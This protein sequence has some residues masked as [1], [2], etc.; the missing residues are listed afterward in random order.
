MKNRYVKMNKLGFELQENAM[1]H[2]S[3]MMRNIAFL[4]RL[5]RNSIVMLTLIF[6]MLTFSFL[7]WGAVTVNGIKYF[8][9]GKNLQID[10]QYDGR[11]SARPQL[12]LNE[13]NIV[14]NWPAASLV[15][16]ASYPKEMLNP[17]IEADGLNLSFVKLD[18][19]LYHTDKMSW[20][21]QDNT[22]S[23]MIP[24]SEMQS[25]ASSSSNT[26]E[27]S[28]KNFAPKNIAITTSWNSQEIKKTREAKEIPVKPV[29][30]IAVKK[31]DQDYLSYLLSSVDKK[32]EISDQVKVIDKKPEDTQVKKF[33]EPV[34]H[35]VDSNGQKIDQNEKNLHKV[36]GISYTSYLVKMILVLS[37]ILAAIFLLAKLF[38][39]IVVG[40]NK[41][42]FLHNSKVVEVLNTTYL[43]PKKQLL[44]VKVYDQVLL[45]SSSENGVTFLS[46]VKNLSDVLKMGEQEVTGKN[47]D[48]DL[49]LQ[50]NKNNF[51]EDR[52][53]LKDQAKLFE[54]TNVPPEPESKVK[55]AISQKM[56]ALKAWQ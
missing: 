48:T 39:K 15:A 33:A 22:I 32:N 41:L 24:L 42:G 25:F 29:N 18:D 13:K 53:V 26:F 4:K 2:K 50:E 7:S 14:I 56:K 43:S 20:R 37:G 5:G 12:T 23:V 36:E 46:E 3:A 40:K 54:S 11:I 51:A 47:F 27:N 30:N 34:F 38:K 17:K 10:F 9:N 52:V 49:S 6:K 31:A 45:L 44:L 28:K 21:V 8:T 55:K 16:N 1:L 35:A 19:K